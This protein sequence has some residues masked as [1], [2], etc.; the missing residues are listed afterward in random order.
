MTVMYPLLVIL[1]YLR[2]VLHVGEPPHQLICFTPVMNIIMC[3]FSLWD[4]PKIAQDW[5]GLRGSPRINGCD[6]IGVDGGRYGDLSH[7]TAELLRGDEC[8]HK[9]EKS[10]LALKAPLKRLSVQGRRVSWVPELIREE[11]AD[12]HLSSPHR[13]AS[14]P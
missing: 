14:L 10:S 9:C 8:G 6:R 12:P 2:H 4:C 13:T 1:S 3:T 7:C 11:D 5:L